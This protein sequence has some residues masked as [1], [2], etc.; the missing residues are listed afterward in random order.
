MGALGESIR[1]VIRGLIDNASLKSTLV[2]TPITR[3]KG[4]EGG[5]K[6]VTETGG[7]TVTVNCLPT[8]FVS[9]RVELLKFGDLK[10]GDVSLIIRDDQ[11]I[12]TDD[13]V[14][15]ESEDY[16]VREI[17]PVPFNEVLV[18]TEI[19]LSEKLD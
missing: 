3:T 7:T 9:D 11:T 15:F 18:A 19:I 16:H 10:T 17:K 12:D 6:A 1:A 4:G 2:L 13:S 5:Y 8:S 14:T